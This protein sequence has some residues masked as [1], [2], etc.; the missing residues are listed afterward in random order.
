MHL[1]QPATALIAGACHSHSIQ[2]Q[3]SSVTLYSPSDTLVFVVMVSKFAIRQQ[4]LSNEV[5]A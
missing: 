5:S 3:E 1:M 4:A 2:P